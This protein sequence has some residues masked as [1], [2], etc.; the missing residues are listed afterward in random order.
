MEYNY[1]AQIVQTFLFTEPPYYLANGGSVL[2]PNQNN[3]IQRDAA[4]YAVIDLTLYNQIFVNLSGRGESS[5]TY[6]PSS[7]G[8]YYYPA[9][10]VAWQ[11]TKLPALEGSKILNMGKL[12]IAYG[13]AGVPPAV[14]TSQT[15]ILGNPTY[16][17]GWGE[18][19][20]PQY[21]GGG[22]GYSTTIGNAGIAPEMTSELEGGLDLTLFDDRVTLSATEYSD[23]TSGA[24]YAIQVTPSIGFSSKQG[25][26]VNITNVGTE[27][28]AN[29]NWIRSGQ[30][31]W[32]SLLNWSTNKNEITS[33]PEGTQ[34][35]ALNGFTDPFSAAVLNQPVG[36]IVGTHWMR[37]GDN[38]LITEGKLIL[39][40]NGFPQNAST[41][42]VI[43]DPNPTW[44]AGIGNTFRYGRFTL[45]FL[46]DFRVGG[47]VWNGTEG[48]LA[49]FG[50]Y[51][52]QNWWT[53][54]TA[55]QAQTLKD[56]NG[57]TVADIV[58][59]GRYGNSYVRN[60]DGTYSFRGYVKN[61]DPSNGAPDVIVDQSWFTSGP[62]SSLTGGASEQ[63]MEDGSFVRLRQASLSYMLP[64]TS[65]GFQSLQISLIGN[66]LALWTKYTGADPETNLTGPTNGQGLD[67]FIN[68]SVRTWVLSLQVNY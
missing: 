38:G 59:S 14:Y 21:W 48:A 50:R 61:F 6:G 1:M 29:I 42:A 68:P 4:A 30:F 44:M 10:S 24:I 36:V 23:K 19:V 35:V 39:D 46:F 49:Y 34:Y 26:V 52:N 32:S 65:L 18:G 20:N 2:P 16:Y 12:R 13:E 45:N 31:S 22:A 8:L 60:A 11:F 57:Q 7:A 41:D 63:F 15:Y 27:L 17:N 33:M 66:N 64:L 51:G 5:S 3:W 55:E 53:T 54:I 58:T 67:Y 62:G 25:N 28:Q 43:G 47:K 9:A 37:T 56:W 40:A